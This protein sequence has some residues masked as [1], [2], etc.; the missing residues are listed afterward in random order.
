RLASL[1]SRAGLRALG[2]A[3]WVADDGAASGLVTSAKVP[4]GLTADQIVERAKPLDAG[5]SRGFGEIEQHLVRLN[6]TGRA[7][8]FTTVLANAVACG[9]ALAG[10]GHPARIGAAADAVAAIYSR[11]GRT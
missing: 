5:F 8:Q 1:A 11:A 7:A 2:A 6:H 4:D 3:P 10:L 9:T